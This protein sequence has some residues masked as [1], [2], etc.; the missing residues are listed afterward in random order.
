[1]HNL[2]QE[3][4]RKHE[5]NQIDFKLNDVNVAA[6]WYRIFGQAGNRLLD[7]SDLPKNVSKRNV[8][9]LILISTYVNNLKTLRRIFPIL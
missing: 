3:P 9:R 4:T 1:M 8:V 6:G 2:L 5:T 7:I